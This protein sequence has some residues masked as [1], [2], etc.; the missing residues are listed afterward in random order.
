MINNLTLLEVYPMQSFSKAYEQAKRDYKEYPSAMNR[1]SN[2]ML[3]FCIIAGLAIAFISNPL[4]GVAIL[5]IPFICKYVGLGLIF[6]GLYLNQLF[7]SA[8][9]PPESSLKVG[10]L[11]GLGDDVVNQRPD[12][13]LIHERTSDDDNGPFLPISDRNPITNV[14]T[15]KVASLIQF[16]SSFASSGRT[17]SDSSSSNESDGIDLRSV[18]SQHDLT[19]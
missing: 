3:P 14:P 4:L 5:S 15:G 16:F 18:A 11:N 10:L 19:I 8:S 6:T 12:D 7:K 13:G 1:A 2:Q 17:R 9:V